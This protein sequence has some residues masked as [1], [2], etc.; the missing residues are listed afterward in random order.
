MTAMTVP[1]P[2]EIWIHLAL[3][4]RQQEIFSRQ[5]EEL[6]LC[7]RSTDRLG[8]LDHLDTLSFR[9]ADEVATCCVEQS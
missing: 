5:A 2:D 6:M 7:N 9:D 3:L 8:K 1:L 4:L